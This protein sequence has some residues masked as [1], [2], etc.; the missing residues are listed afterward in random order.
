MANK[1]YLVYL[2]T[3]V[4]D[5]LVG[6]LTSQIKGTKESA[7]FQYDQTWLESPHAF[8]LAPDLPL[9]PGMFFSKDKMFGAF[10]DCAPDRWGRKLM[11][12]YEQELATIESRPQKTLNEIDYILRVN[13]FARQ[14]ALRFKE[15]ENGEFL[16]TTVS[17]AVPPLTKLPELLHA[18]EA[19]ND[20]TDTNKEL[21]L[22]LAPGSSLGGARPKAS[23]VDDNNNLCI[24]KFPKK[25]D[26]TR[27]VVWEAI[28]LDLARR[29]GL[30]VPDF[31]F[32]SIMNKDVLIIKRFDRQGTTRIPFAS[33]MTMLNAIDNDMNTY[34][35]TEI[36]DFLIQNG[37]KPDEDLVELW[38]RI[39][40]SVLISNTDDHLRN[41]GFLH[42][43]KGWILS[44][45]Y[46]VNPSAEKTDTFHTA[47]AEDNATASIE[48]A[49][50]YAKYFRIS[51]PE[52]TTIVNSMTT[53]ISNWQNVAK[54][55]GLPQAEITRMSPAF[56][57]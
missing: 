7:G 28:A 14:G 9:A 2:S 48:N 37:A 56:K 20:K 38:K 51:A 41:H 13:D 47:I 40:F 19:I 30:N 35:Y 36:A 46:D 1:K 8:G 21:L 25:D 26:D 4:G 33:A 18:A 50:Q 39:V 55:Y 44:P 27:V 29:C 15:A 6:Y 45:L 57:V 31:Q 34:N 16:T 43:N 54:H 23:V 11:I 5:T 32:K 17:G 52:A 49:L 10:E 42:I 24:A 12:R 53:V 3:D 22:L